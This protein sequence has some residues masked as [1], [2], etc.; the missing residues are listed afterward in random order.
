MK[1]KDLIT[2]QKLL[3]EFY[4]LRL[5]ELVSTKCFKSCNITE[6]KILI[7]VLS[8]REFICEFM[9]VDSWDDAK[10]KFKSFFSGL[11]QKFGEKMA[12]AFV[13]AMKI[14][15]PVGDK[16]KQIKDHTVDFSYDVSGDN[17][18]DLTDKEKIKF[19]QKEFLDDKKKI[20][21]FLRKFGEAGKHIEEILDNTH[22]FLNDHPWLTASIN[23]LF[24]TLLGFIASGVTGY[25]AFVVI[26]IV[27]FALQDAL[28]EKKSFQKAL[29][30]KM[31][32][33]FIFRLVS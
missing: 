27:F 13:V 3:N 14:I 23:I 12:P 6:Q 26:G 17:R 21:S 29:V 9:G 33:R 4:S 2:E 30:E 7:E 16:L 5:N 15:K 31:T 32:T 20:Q 11:K 22:E 18:D 25:I 19:D 24:V 28:K 1:L 8:D 10:K